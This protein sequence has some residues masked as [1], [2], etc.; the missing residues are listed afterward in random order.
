MG[1]LRARLWQSLMVYCMLCGWPTTCGS[2]QDGNSDEEIDYTMP[3]KN[4]H[5]TKVELKTALKAK[6]KQLKHSR[7]KQ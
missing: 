6:V 1:L 2:Q 5:R 7:Y 4:E 3:S